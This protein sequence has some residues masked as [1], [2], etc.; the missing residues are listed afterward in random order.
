LQARKRTT[1]LEVIRRLDGLIPN[2]ERSSLLKPTLV[3]LH[4]DKRPFKEVLAALSKQTGYGIDMDNNGIN[5][6]FTFHFDKKPFWEVLDKVAKEGKLSV[7]PYNY[8]GNSNDRLRLVTYGTPP[9]P[10][11][12]YHQSFRLVPSGFNYQR[13]ITFTGS[14]YGKQ[15]PVQRSE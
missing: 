12:Q 14:Y 3:S 9:G 6:T 2:L 8:Y 11:V 10:Y 5:D 4:I 7:Y 1:D 13:N 15:N